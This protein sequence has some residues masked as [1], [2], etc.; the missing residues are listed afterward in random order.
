MN[1]RYNNPYYNPAA[2][3]FAQQQQYHAQAP[4]HPQY[5]PPPAQPIA[6]SGVLLQPAVVPSSGFS[7]SSSGFLKGAAI[8]AIAAYLLSN[9]RLQQGAIKTAVK[10][11]S[12]LQ[13]GVE[14]MK[15][16]FRD[17][18]AELHAAQQHDDG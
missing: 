6:P 15:E 10:S 16:R 13:G 12:L 9:E 1:N 8:G 5:S 14:E 11:W 18:E 17:A 4:M 2:T 7:V 3:Y